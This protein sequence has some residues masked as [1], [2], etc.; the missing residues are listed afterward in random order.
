MSR[1]EITVQGHRVDVAETGSGPPLLYLHGFCDVHGAVPG[2]LALH[3]ALARRFTVIAP[4]HP[5]CAGSEENDDIDAVDDATFHLLSVMDALGLDSVPVVGHCIGGWLAAELAVRHRERVECLCLIAA[6]GLK[7]A[8]EPIADLFWQLQPL[9]GTDRSGL[10]RLLF[11]EAGSALA[12]EFY[13]DGR[14]EIDIELLRYKMC[15]FAS[16]I[17]FRPPYFQD[18]KLLGRLAR[19]DRP[20]LVLSGCDDRLVPAAHGA[21]Y[22]AGLGDARLEVLDDAGH[23]LHIERPEKVADTVEGFLVGNT[24][25]R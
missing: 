25:T 2:W 1:R 19:Y 8:G 5:G 23:C 4:A 18:P 6:S 11:A 3:E 16:R 10:R 14:N 13:P 7:V 17:G 15:R 9:D 12:L 21:A 20:A 22:A 24:K